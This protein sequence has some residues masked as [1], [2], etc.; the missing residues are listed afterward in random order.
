[1]LVVLCA[2]VHACAPHLDGS[3]EKASLAS[4]EYLP[5]AL[6]PPTAAYGEPNTA[7]QIILECAPTEQALRIEFVDTEIAGDRLVELRVA[8]TTFRGIE[9]LQP[10]DGFAVS[11]ISVPWHEA[12][13]ERYGAGAGPIMIITKGEKFQIP[14]GQSPRRMVK[15]CLDLRS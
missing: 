7:V 15:D 4:W 6:A 14:D 10:P 3:T 11:R 5:Q 12:I 8:G 2:A 13:L 1:M 9:R